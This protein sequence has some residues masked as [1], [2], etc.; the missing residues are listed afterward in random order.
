MSKCKIFDYRLL[1]FFTFTFVSPLYS[2]KRPLD[3]VYKLIG[4]TALEDMRCVR[5]APSKF[6]IQEARTYL[7]VTFPG[8]EKNGVK[9]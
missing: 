7:N 4:G 8:D 5:R 2:M 9:G 6:I 1:L 3:M